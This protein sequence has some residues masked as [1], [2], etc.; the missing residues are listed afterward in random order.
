M[1][2]SVF[3]RLSKGYMNATFNKL[4][5]VAVVLTMLAGCSFNSAKP[6]GAQSIIQPRD[7]QLG[8]IPN[9]LETC[10][11]DVGAPFHFRKS[12]LVAG[13][14]GLPVIARDLPGLSSVTSERLQ[15]H[16]E[17]LEKFNVSAMHDSSFEST[18]PSTAARVRELGRDYASQFVVK[19]DIE[20]LTIKS[21]GGWWSK[22]LGRKNERDILLKLHV[23]DTEHGALFYSQQYQE[24]V[25][26]DVIGFPGNG[27]SVTISWF[28]TDLGRQ[29]DSLLQIMSEQIN[30]KLACVPFSTQ[31]TSTRD[32]ELHIAAGYLHGI[33]PGETLRI[34]PSNSISVA[35]GSPVAGGKKVWIQVNSVYPTHSIAK[36]SQGT[37]NENGLATGDIVRAW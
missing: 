27:N 31:V 32:N 14:I 29:V 37:V 25:T 17:A 22:L 7:E 30:E 10:S 34:Y 3:R 6:I 35:N 15:T 24:T 5:T 4:A 8:E 36:P 12:V 2:H 26:G 11:A 21:H 16:L 9:S 19:V 33:R 18:S 28:E 13:T 1:C 20:D 23:Y